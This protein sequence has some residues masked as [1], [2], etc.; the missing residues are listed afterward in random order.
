MGQTTRPKHSRGQDE[1]SRRTGTVESPGDQK[2]VV[3]EDPWVIVP[4][5]ELDEEAADDPTKEIAG[6]ALVVR[7]EVRI[8]DELGHVDL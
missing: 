2:R 3:F 6:L 8:L 5:V 7:D 4:E 1:K